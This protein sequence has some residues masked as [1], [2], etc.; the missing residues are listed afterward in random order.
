V[1]AKNIITAIVHEQQN[2]EEYTKSVHIGIH[3][4]LKR[5][6]SISSHSKLAATTTTTA[7]TTTTSTGQTVI[8]LAIYALS[9]FSI[10][11]KKKKNKV[12]SCSRRV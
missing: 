2:R 8:F 4:C 10:P 5:K 3:I 11:K 6:T 7:K 9:P 12:N 1:L